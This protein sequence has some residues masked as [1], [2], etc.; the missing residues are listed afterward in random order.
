M[1]AIFAQ[2]INDKPHLLASQPVLMQM[3]DS[4]HIE[5]E[6]LVNLLVVFNQGVECVHLISPKINMVVEQSYV[7]YAGCVVSN[8]APIINV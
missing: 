4:S 3:C 2:S 1:V 8:H 6:C 7:M 5:S